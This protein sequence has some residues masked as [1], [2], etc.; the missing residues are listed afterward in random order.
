[1]DDSDDSDG[2]DDSDDDDYETIIMKYDLD[3]NSID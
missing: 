3:F 2:L 1:M